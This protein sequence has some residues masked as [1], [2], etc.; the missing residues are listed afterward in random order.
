MAMTVGFL[1]LVPLTLGYLTVRPVVG[2]SLRFRFFAPWVTCALVIL[3]S[4][5]VGLEGAVSS[6]SLRPQCSSSHLSEGCWPERSPRD[7]AP[8]FRLPSF[9]RGW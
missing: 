5:L 3:G 2:P 7:L 6:C 8:T 9:S 1:F 4:V